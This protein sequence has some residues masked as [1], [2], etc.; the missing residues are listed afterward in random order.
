M[1]KLLKLLIEISII[2]TLVFN[3]KYFS[4]KDAIK[5]PVFI[6]KHVSLLDLHGSI[7]LKSPAYTGMIRIGDG[8]VGIYDKK[9]R[10]SIWEVSGK[11]EFGRNVHIGHGSKNKCRKKGIIIIR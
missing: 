9:L 5:L 6:Y 2:K 3:L 10:R 1:K 7:K 4:I 8:Y 11:I